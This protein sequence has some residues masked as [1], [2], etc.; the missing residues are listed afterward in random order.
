MSPAAPDLA[1]LARWDTPALSNALRRTDA[2][3]DGQEYT[4]GSIHRV[5]GPTMAGIAVTATMRARRPGGDAVPVAELHRAVLAVGGPAV[6]VVQDLDEEPGAGAFLGE[7]NGTLLAALRI[8][9]FVTNGRVRDVPD[10]QGMGFAVHAAGACVARAHMR[11][12]AVGVPVRVAGL[13]VAPGDLLHGDG[14][15][16]LKIPAAAAPA[17]PALA[18]AVRAE[19][20]EVVSWARSA[21]F[22]PERLLALKRVRH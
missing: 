6:V 12:T 4:D 14:H 1:A 15:G 20:Q 17:L 10:L 21:D 16:V 2:G 9:G 11:L 19:E 7:V 3:A 8:S 22:T 18:E 13:D 5:A